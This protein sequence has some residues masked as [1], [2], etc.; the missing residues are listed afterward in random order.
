MNIYFRSWEDNTNMKSKL[1]FKLILLI[2]FSLSYQLLSACDIVYYPKANIGDG[3]LLSGVPCSAPCFWHI[4]PGIT[5]KQET[6]KIFYSELKQYFCWNWDHRYESGLQG[7]SCSNL[8][9]SFDENE[10]VN[11]INFDLTQDISVDKIIQNFGK[12]DNI[13]VFPVGMDHFPPPT[14]R[15][16]LY[17]KKQNMI[18]SLQDQNGFVYDLKPNTLISDISYVKSDEFNSLINTAKRW[19][20]YKDY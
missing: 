17:Y 18:V 15:M 2:I 12:P 20:G 6:K 13:D 7:I 9:V 19:D 5:T 10:I 16:Q 1:F 3:G 11:T 14:L 8:N 4:T